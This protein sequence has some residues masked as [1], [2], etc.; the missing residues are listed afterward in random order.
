MNGTTIH[1][2]SRKKAYD[3]ATLSNCLRAIAFFAFFT[4]TVATGSSQTVSFSSTTYATSVPINASL[5]THLITADFNGDGKPDLALLIDGVPPMSPG[6]VV[7]L[8][9]N[10]DGTFQTGIVSGAGTSG[11]S[12]AAGDF[13]GDGK[14][15]LVVANFYD[16]TVTVLLGNGDGTFQ[17]GKTQA[18]SSGSGFGSVWYVVAGD[19]NKDGKQDL[20]VALEAALG[21]A[22]VDSIGILLGNGDGTFATP[23]LY[24]SGQNPRWIGIGDFN[25]DKNLDLVTTNT[26]SANVSVFLG[27][28]DGTFQPQLTSATAD[29]PAFGAIGDFNHDG[30]ADIAVNASGNPS[31]TVL[32]GKGDGTFTTSQ[33]ITLQS[34]YPDWITT[35]D[36]DGDG[37]LDL[38]VSGAFSPPNTN[39]NAL[40]FLG[41]GD[42]TFENPE[43]FSSGSNFG[44]EQAIVTADFNGDGKPDLAVG[45]GATSYKADSAAVTALINST[46]ASALPTIAAAVNGA[47]FAAGGLAAGSIETL[48]G[49]NLTSANGINLAAALPLP[50]Q[51]LNI[52]VTVDGIAAPIFAIDNV[53]GQQQ[54]NFQAPFELAG[55]TNASIQVS[56]NGVMSKAVVFP[57]VEAQPGIFAYST[58]GL[59][60]GAIL[61]A[62]FQLADT[63]HPAKAGETVL[64]YCTGLGAVLS[65][66]ADGAAA[67]GQR[68]M[69][70]A[71]VTIGGTKA[72]VSFS[73]LAPGFVGLYQINAEIPSGLAAGN[74]TVVASVGNASSNS[75]LLP[76]E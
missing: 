44:A 17:T 47:S 22:A 1:V 68:T 58:S 20:A 45:N 69:T 42:G 50:T 5:F 30:K 36:F 62:N 29:R 27:K 74:Q 8:L 12:I 31:V 14:L 72:V 59:T 15:D 75:V 2:C 65:P 3:G 41:K 52:S 55:K 33:T 26:H 16:V 43:L 23:V 13:N 40:V 61:H 63:A 32:L 4:W 57:I 9:G 10:G 64:I 39:L 21:G 67:N 18:A 48:F 7:V 54:I 51:L 66:P 56:N 25:N 35:A 60:F 70:T 37:K 71:T 24:P 46:V 49:S 38:A 76:I 28:G 11:R 34:G 73:G 19:F 53:N 6:Y